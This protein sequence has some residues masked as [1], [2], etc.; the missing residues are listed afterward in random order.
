MCLLCDKMAP[1]CRWATAKNVEDYFL[2]LPLHRSTSKNVEFCENL[3]EEL[4]EGQ[5]NQDEI[6]A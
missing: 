1:K 2:T 3:L 4:N 6:H 5:D